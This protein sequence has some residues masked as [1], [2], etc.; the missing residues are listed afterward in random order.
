M[1]LLVIAQQSRNTNYTIA[2]GISIRPGQTYSARNPQQF[3]SV[4]FVGRFAGQRPIVAHLRRRTDGTDGTDGADGTARARFWT[5]YD[6]VTG[7][8]T[9]L[10]SAVQ[11]KH[12]VPT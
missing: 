7:N 10:S 5:G 2:P 6:G 11:T 12:Q 3:R 1:I 9:Q 4:L 8:V